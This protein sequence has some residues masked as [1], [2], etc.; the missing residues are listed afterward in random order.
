MKATKL[1]AMVTAVS[2]VFAG[3]AKVSMSDVSLTSTKGTVDL[4]VETNEAVYGIQ[5]DLKYDTN[6]LSF[7]GA[8]ATINGIEFHYAENTPGLVRGLLFSMQGKQLNDNVF[9]FVDFDF[10]PADGYNGQSTISFEDVVL[11]GIIAEVVTG[12]G[13]GQVVMEQKTPQ[14]DQEALLR[15]KAEKM[16][17]QRQAKIKRLNESAGLAKKVNV[18]EGVKPM[19]ESS[20]SGPSPLANINPGDSG[21]DISGIMNI[22]RHN[23]KDLI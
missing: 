4:Q 13:A 16:E 9:S 8:E 11:S 15:E 22:S 7:N 1:I 12:L 3:A 18:F 17:A 6:Q 23:W 20:P 19:Q 10:T 5:F 2:M 14:V 21:V